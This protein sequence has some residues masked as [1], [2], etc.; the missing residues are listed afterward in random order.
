MGAWNTMPPFRYLTVR[1]I[2]RFVI[3][4]QRGLMDRFGEAGMRVD[5]TLDIFCTG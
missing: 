5:S 4:S 2:Q 3:D 1:E